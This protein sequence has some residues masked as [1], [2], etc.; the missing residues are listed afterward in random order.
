MF[1]GYDGGLSDLFSVNRDGSGPRRLTQDKYADLH[2][3]WSP[4]GKTIAF[5]TDR[6]PGTDFKT[7]AFGNF[8]I[9]LY[10][11]AT[12]T[13][14]VLDHMD[15]GKNVSPQWA[16]DGKLDRLRVGPERGQQHLPVRPGRAARSTSSPTSTPARRASPR[17]R[18]CCRW[19][20]EADRLAFVYYEDEQ[21]RRLHH[22]QPAWRSSG[23]R[24]SSTRRTAS[25][26]LARVATP[27]LDTTR[28]LQVRG[29][30]SGPQVGE[31]GSIYRTPTG[32]RSSSEVART[33]DTAMARRAGL[34]RRPDRLG[35]LQPAGHQRVHA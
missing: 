8:R 33:G 25:A 23:S 1:T 11:L 24:T 4:D 27:P 18:R 16:P 10:D 13:I 26:I 5:A 7:L 35:Q 9:A 20:R 17:S 29:G 15:Q 21:V 28:S 30:R 3:V 22:H 19:A 32:F 34:D 31:G 12:G 6:G 2:P 14:R